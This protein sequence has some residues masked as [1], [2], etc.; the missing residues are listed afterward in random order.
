MESYIEFSLEEDIVADL[1]QSL[2][3]TTELQD[4]G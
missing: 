4:E 2:N 1:S 3:I